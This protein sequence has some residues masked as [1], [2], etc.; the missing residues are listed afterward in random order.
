MFLQAS[1]HRFVRSSARRRGLATNLL[2]TNRKHIIAAAVALS[3]LAA[4]QVRLIGDITAADPLVCLAAIFLV[5]LRLRRRTVLLT[6]GLFA[7]FV[8]LQLVADVDNGSELVDSTR[9]IGRTIIIFSYC[10]LFLLLPTARTM[11]VRREHLLAVVT[12]GVLV[13]NLSDLGFAG[14]S[15]YEVWR[16]G[17]GETLTILLLWFASMCV[18][19]WLGAAVIGLGLLVNIYFNFRAMAIVTLATAMYYL[20]TRVRAALSARQAIAVSLLAVLLVVP[21]LWWFQE[22]TTTTR[23]QTSDLVRSALAR[24]VMNDFLE[25]R[26]TGNGA[27]SFRKV[28]QPPFTGNPAL[29]ERLEDGLNIHGYVFTY[30]YECGVLAYMIWVVILVSVV[31]RLL[32]LRGVTSGFDFAVIVYFLIGAVALALSGYDKYIVAYGVAWVMSAIGA[33]R[34]RIYR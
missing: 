32:T 17:V 34:R 24:T 16:H 6:V 22:A 31:H 14:D 5:F 25:F 4:A 9:A 11:A 26:L 29:D 21:V 2:V 18:G 23:S 13:R 8:G 1:G 20:F 7:S 10:V 19:P 3:Y 15:T 12:L 28:F 30:G 33:T 27:N